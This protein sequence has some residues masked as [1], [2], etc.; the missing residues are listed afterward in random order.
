MS[1]LTIDRATVTASYLNNKWDE[2]VRVF[3]TQLPPELRYLDDDTPF[4]N[5]SLFEYDVEAAQVET[6]GDLIP[7][8]VAKA[9]RLGSSLYSSIDGDDVSMSAVD[10]SSTI[11]KISLLR[12][13]KPSE[14]DIEKPDID[15]YKD[16]LNQGDA[17][18]VNSAGG[19]S[20]NQEAT[21][22]VSNREVN[23]FTSNLLSANSYGN[24]LINNTARLTIGND[25]S[26]FIDINLNQSSDSKYLDGNKVQKSPI[27]T[28]SVMNKNSALNNTYVQLETGDRVPLSVLPKTTI[29][30]A[31]DQITKE[32][33]EDSFIRATETQ[34]QQIA[35]ISLNTIT[36][37]ITYKKYV[38]SS[39]G[40]G[41]FRNGYLG[42]ENFDGI[43]F[44]EWS[45][46]EKQII[47]KLDFGID[48]KKANSYGNGF[49]DWYVDLS[50]DVGNPEENWSNFPEGVTPTIP[51]CSSSTAENSTTED[52]TSQI[53]GSR[54]VFTTSKP[55]ESGTLKVYWN[56]QRQSDQTITELT[57]TT[58]S[59]TFVPSGNNVLIVDYL[60]I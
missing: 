1:N 5:L 57:S 25:D 54:T 12:T 29:Q 51:N 10:L 30:K 14:F 56:G 43:G 3:A 11:G 7:A 41:W 32:E 21:Y 34:I 31:L 48:N 17:V 60:L 26:E 22:D 42:T 6:V 52:L 39:T 2:Y 9:N 37:D 20:F 33:D 13:K 27:S 8:I 53:N 44:N 4:E 58:F 50:Y 38:N 15:A 59:T 18:P 19:G 40:Q 45:V 46:G 23:N 24:L 35:T 49:N 47:T 28:F 16:E 36:E 55:Y